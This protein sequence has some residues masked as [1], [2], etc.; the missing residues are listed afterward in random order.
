M[1]LYQKY[2]DIVNE[3]K[4]IEV[5][6]FTT[7]NLDAELVERY[8]ISALV[9]IEPSQLKT[10]E[11][12]EALN[13]DLNNIDVKVCY[14]YRAINLNSPKRT[15]ID[16]IPVNPA[17]LLSRSSQSIFHPK[18]I[19]LKGKRVAYLISGSANLSISAW[20]SNKEAVIIKKIDDRQNAARIIDFFNQLG[21]KNKSVN[22][23]KNT[24][25][26]KNTD[27][28]FVHSLKNNF[29]LFNDSLLS[30]GSEGLT[31]WSPYFSREAHKFLSQ[32]LDSGYEHITI[33]PNINENGKMSIEQSEL[34]AII[35][36]TKIDVKHFQKADENQNLHHAKVWLTK[37]QLAVGSWNC[38]YRAT[39]FRIAR[40][41]KNIEAGVIVDIHNSIVAGRLLDNLMFFDK[42]EHIN[43]HS[44]EELKKQW[45]DV[46]NE[47]TISLEIIA[48]WDTFAYRLHQPDEELMRKGYYVSLPHSPNERILLKEINN[49]SFKEHYFRVLKNKFF[50]VYDGAG[51][52]IFHGYLQET[53]KTKRPVYTYVNLTDLFESLI[54]NPV[55][56]TE[57]RACKY[58]LPDETDNAGQ[59]NEWQTLGH[60]SA[61]SYYIM[62]VSFQKLYDIIEELSQNEP[63]LD[64]LGFR[65]PGSLL[66]IKG[67][68]EESF[69]KARE[70][71]NQDKLLYHLFLILE[72]NRCIKLFNKYSNEKLETISKDYL[73]QI[74]ALLKLRKKDKSFLN[75]LRREFAY[76]AV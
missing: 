65:L 41:E 12:Y 72:T 23:W 70:K 5:A 17:Q 26:E 76:E 32:L 69:Q 9:G 2:R 10:A 19:F 51:K 27:W 31:I 64:K 15:C 22:K 75:K 50:T 24:L 61:D 66:N 20:S 58:K 21:I 73:E 48:N 25:T 56:S 34:E 4:P 55:N 28:H 18:L 53:G 7:F 47:F 46:L 45:E 38:S 49:L 36:D 44:R 74:V 29:N 67:L 33:V 71:K 40:K 11:D 6:W 30:P 43:G 13:I 1:K 16:F 57:K 54:T 63:E 37:E 62:F 52:E 8:L 42:P 39:G 59:E 68:V 14:D 3:L 60:K 35:K